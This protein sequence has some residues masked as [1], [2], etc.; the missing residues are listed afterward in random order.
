MRRSFGSKPSSPPTTPPAHAGPRSPAA[1]PPHPPER[2]RSRPSREPRARPGPGAAVVVQLPSSATVVD[3][4][5]S[6]GRC[7][8]LSDDHP[9]LVAC[10]VG[11]LAVGQEVTVEVVAEVAGTEEEVR[12]VASSTAVHPEST[13]NVA[14]RRLGS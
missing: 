4:H 3:A 13:N 5:A 8:D 7:T 14:T 12:V 9:G 6:D 2:H 11:D 10:S 1:R